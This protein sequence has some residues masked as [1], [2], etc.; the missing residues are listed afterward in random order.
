M[1]QHRM[2]ETIIDIP[3][4]CVTA[5]YISL[6]EHSATFKIGERKDSQ[7]SEQNLPIHSSEKTVKQRKED[8][9]RL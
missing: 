5:D 1:V 2:S 6:Y 3:Q 8:L 4:Q 9:H 7:V